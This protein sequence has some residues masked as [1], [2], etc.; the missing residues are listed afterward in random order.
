MTDVG[1]FF[2]ESLT[3]NSTGTFFT[4]CKSGGGRCAEVTVIRGST[5]YDVNRSRMFSLMCDEYTD[6][7][8]K[9]QLSMCVRWIDDSLNPHEDF[10]GF[11]ELPNIAS[12]TIVSAIKDSLTR[13]RL[14]LSELR[15]QSY[16]GAS[17]MLRKR[18]GVAAQIKRVQPK[19]IETHCHRHSLNLLV[20]DAEDKQCARNSC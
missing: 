4:D 18:S 11:Y 2:Y 17:N 10:L 12:D 16:E 13:F 6:V 5:V 8:N 9:Q 15:G 3:L 14:L 1:R 7:S 19:V 20:K